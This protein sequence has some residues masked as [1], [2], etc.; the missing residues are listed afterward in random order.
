MMLTNSKESQAE[1]VTNKDASTYTPGDVAEGAKKWPTMRQLCLTESS[2]LESLI[3]FSTH[4]IRIPDTRCCGTILRVLRSIIPEFANVRGVD[5][6]TSAPI[7]EFISTEVLQAAIT[8][9]HEPYFVDLQRELAQLIATI[10]IWYCPITATPKQVLMSLPGLQESA[11]DKCIDYVGR[12]GMQSRQQ[13][14]IVLDLLRDLKGVSI[15]EQGRILGS[16]AAVRKERSKMQQEFMQTE[17]QKEEVSGLGRRTPEFE[18][19]GALFGDN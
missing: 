15:S 7:R 10:L 4:L 12:M 1:A 18:G 2:I 5:N 13:R 19:L 16:A 6:Q 17:Q 14:A 9:L 11:V 3:L 8:S